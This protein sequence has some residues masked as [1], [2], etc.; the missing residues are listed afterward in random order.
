MHPMRRAA[1]R[2][3]PIKTGSLS[4]RQARQDRATVVQPTCDKC[5]Y[6]GGCSAVGQRARHN[7]QLAKLIIA[8]ASELVDVQEAKLLVKNDPQVSDLILKAKVWKDNGNRG[9]VNTS[10]TSATSQPDKLSLGSVK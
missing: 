9:P 10:Q 8:G 1:Q 7:P 4:H 6:K 2:R 5:M 3:T